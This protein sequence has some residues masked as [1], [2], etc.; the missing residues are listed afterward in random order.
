M[1]PMS[2]IA[3]AVAVLLFL[4]GGLCVLSVVVQL[5]GAWAFL[6]LALVVELADGLYLPEGATTTFAWPVWV[7]GLVLAG[8]GDLLELLAAALGVKKG[9]GS[10]RGLIGAIVGGILGV[11]LTPFFA[12]VPFLGVLL[13]VLLGTFLGALLGELSHARHTMGTALVPALWA[14]LGRL[15]GTTGKVALATAVWLLFAASAFWP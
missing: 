5:P 7:T 13:A 3:L 12:W 2:W 10:R 1:G 4:L 8:L 15:L 9:G 6:A 14:A 11:F